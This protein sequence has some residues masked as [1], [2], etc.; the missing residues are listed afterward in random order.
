MEK[1]SW[2]DKFTKDLDPY[3]PL[4]NVVGVMSVMSSTSS[5]IFDKVTLWGWIICFLLKYQ[6]WDNHWF[7]MLF[8]SSSSNIIN[9]KQSE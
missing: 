3:W 9:N 5:G 8:I 1:W 6:I 7:F 4:M 2:N